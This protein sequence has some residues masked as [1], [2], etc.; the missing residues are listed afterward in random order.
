M[1][2][3]IYL[4]CY[5][6]IQHLL[7]PHIALN[8][9]IQRTFYIS[10]MLSVF[11]LVAIFSYI[12][13]SSALKAEAAL[14]RERQKSE[15][16]LL[17]ILP[18]SIVQ[19]L[20]EDKS[21]IADY[22]E[23]T[24]VLFADIVG[25]TAMSAKIKPAELVQYLNKIFS[26][27]DDLVEKYK[28]EKV[29]TIGDAYMVGGGFPEPRHDHVEAIADLALEMQNSV[30]EIT[31]GINQIFDIRIGIHTGPAVAGVIGISKIAYDVWGDTVNT[32]SRMESHGIPGQIQLSEQTYLQLK[33]KYLFKERGRIE[34]KGKEKMKTYLLLGKQLL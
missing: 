2:F 24:T 8:S 13:S 29:K 17:N 28:L 10:N 22:F 31:T 1:S 21:V 5:Y 4:V 14:E 12:Y 33:D 32:A 25:F 9:V 26:V 23:S 27:F 7:A 11:F 30:A 15:H 3:I 6:T 34:I 20:K 19:R 16:L 18:C